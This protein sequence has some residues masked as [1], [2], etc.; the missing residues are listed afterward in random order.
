MT[1][2][3]KFD[4][5]LSGLHSFPALGVNGL[6]FVIRARMDGDRVLEQGI[7]KYQLTPDGKY[8]QGW[9]QTMKTL[10][11]DIAAEA[12]YRYVNVD[13]TLY[14]QNKPDKFTPPN[15]SPKDTVTT[16]YLY[17]EN[18]ELLNE[19][20]RKGI[21]V[22]SLPPNKPVYKLLMEGPKGPVEENRELLVVDEQNAN[23]K[24]TPREKWRGALSVCQGV[25]RIAV[26]TAF[27][28]KLEILSTE[29]KKLKE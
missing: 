8:N 25:D 28:K 11:T 15:T 27:Y 19:W 1:P 14:L 13:G 6:V 5:R 9:N 24:L 20:Q 22:G 4:I 17:D 29:G 16:T 23:K 21:I 10:P 2:V 26:V 12:S 18:F 3:E 7:A